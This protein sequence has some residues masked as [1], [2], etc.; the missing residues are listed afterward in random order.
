MED[1]G[2]FSEFGKLKYG[3]NNFLAEFIT[4]IIKNF[5]SVSLIIVCLGDL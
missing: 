3:A 5:F 4:V 1:F 2:R